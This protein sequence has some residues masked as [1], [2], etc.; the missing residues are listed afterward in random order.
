M[1]KA[2]VAG[3]VAGWLAGRPAEN[4]PPPCW[5]AQLLLNQGW[6]AVVMIVLVLFRSEV[7]C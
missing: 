2:M 3:W 5:L 6:H 1:Y 7:D 4:P